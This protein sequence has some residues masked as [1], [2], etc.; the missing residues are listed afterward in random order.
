MLAVPAKV[1][2]A[3]PLSWSDWLLS[4]S[5]ICTCTR[6]TVPV[7]TRAVPV[8]VNGVLFA[9]TRPSIGAVIVVSGSGAG[10]GLAS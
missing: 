8:I 2:N 9:T 6:P 10:N 7:V 4:R 1:V 3:V 5:W